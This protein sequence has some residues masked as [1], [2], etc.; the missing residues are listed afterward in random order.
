MYEQSDNANAS[1]APGAEASD[2][3]SASGHETEPASTQPEMVP[4][5]KASNLDVKAALAAQ[6][7]KDAQEAQAPEAGVSAQFDSAPEQKS[8]GG[9]SP[10]VADASKPAQPGAQR[11]RTQE[12]VRALVAENERGKAE[13]QAKELF[14]QRRNTELGNLRTENAKR[15]KQFED[16]RNQLMQGLNAK[17]QEDPAG[18]ISDGE[19]IKELDGHLGNLNSSE[20]YAAQEVEAQSLFVSHIDTQKVGPEDLFAVL[21]HDGVDEKFISHFRSNFWSTM[22]PS[23]LLQLGK[24]A[25]DHKNLR[26]LA[27]HIQ[28]QDEK[29][30]R[31]EGRASGVVR[32]IKRNLSQPAQVT[33]HSPAATATAHNLNPAAIPNLSRDELK[34]ALNAAQRAEGR[35]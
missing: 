28:G 35:G 18:A 9:D 32:N 19:K 29:I 22:D 23:A 31:L 20:Q 16:L 15:R 17:F 4:L 26:L 1:A 5:D 2:E 14:I 34:R 24:R 8:V 21:K 12:E 6:I 10:P 25:E 7:A 3:T 11:P 27:R 33:A 13:R 30:A